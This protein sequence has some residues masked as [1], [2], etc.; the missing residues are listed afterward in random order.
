MVTFTCAENSKRSFPMNVR[1]RVQRFQTSCFLFPTL[2]M[3]LHFL[4]YSHGSNTR[5]DSTPRVCS[6]PRAWRELHATS[7][8]NFGNYIIAASPQTRCTLPEIWNICGLL[9]CPLPKP[10]CLTG[11]R[12]APPYFPFAPRVL[13]M[14][15]NYWQSIV[16]IDARVS[17]SSQNSLCLLT[18]TISRS[19][20]TFQD[21]LLLLFV[22]L[23]GHMIKPRKKTV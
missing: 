7:C 16:V 6:H 10:P 17:S 5:D 12:E 22:I 14:T 21:P 20:L 15:A 13:W 11:L 2:P 9:P 1:L 19:K 23:P 18:K 3:C 8:G 4:W